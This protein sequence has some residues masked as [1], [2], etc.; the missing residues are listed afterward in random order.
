M[1]M[2]GVAV[3]AGVTVAGYRHSRP[4]A[5]QPPP[6]PPVQM[7][8]DSVPDHELL[9][10]VLT[11]LAARQ[12]SGPRPFPYLPKSRPADLQ[13]LQS[14]SVGQAVVD[15]YLVQGGDLSVKVAVSAEATPICSD[16][17][18]DKLNGL[19]LRDEALR[20]AAVDGVDYRHLVVYV[21]DR[22]GRT[23]APEAPGL[24]EVRRFWGTVEMVP[25]NEATWFS[26]LGTRARQAPTY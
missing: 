23:P 6:V 17:R 7:V 25:V 26:E 24:N 4:D 14:G 10:D 20:P 9:Q 8:S 1:V 15:T 11:I 2:I 21:T 5:P 16:L 22:V 12:G 18:T 3:A 19:C 13:H